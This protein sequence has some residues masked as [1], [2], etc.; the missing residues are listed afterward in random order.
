MKVTPFTRDLLKAYREEK[1]KQKQA[2]QQRPV[3]TAPK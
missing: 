1:A 3:E 2:E